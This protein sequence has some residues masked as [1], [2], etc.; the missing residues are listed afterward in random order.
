[1]YFPIIEILE[2]FFY[3]TM[4][5]FACKICFHRKYNRDLYMKCI[6]EKN[7]SAKAAFASC[8]TKLDKV[9]FI[10]GHMVLVIL[11]LVLLTILIINIR[12]TS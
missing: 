7:M 12:S 1:M 11:T 3:D 9:D 2:K 6:H 4:D 5:F 8:P 10:L